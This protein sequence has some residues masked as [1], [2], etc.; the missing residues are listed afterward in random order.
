MSRECHRTRCFVVLEPTRPLPTECLRGPL[1]APTPKNPRQVSPRVTP[2][3][4]STF[5]YLLAFSG[6]RWRC[7]VASLSWLFRGFF[8]ALI[9][10]ENSVAFSRMAPWS[11]G[12]IYAYS[13]WNLSSESLE[14]FSKK[15]L[16]TLKKHS[17]DTVPETSPKT[18]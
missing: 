10:L 2:K 14:S 7:F 9:C 1:R 15:S 8:V 18:S 16:G 4:R 13:P 11:L 3:I 12:K 17:P 5:R 6:T